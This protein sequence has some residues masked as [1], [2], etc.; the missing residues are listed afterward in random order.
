MRQGGGK[1]Q[2]GKSGWGSALTGLVFLLLATPLVFAALS[3]GVLFSAL[4]LLAGLIWRVWRSTPG[5]GVSVAITE[6]DEGWYLQTDA[7]PARRIMTLRAG[8]V[9]P[10]L[11]SA[12]LGLAKGG[13]NLLV[14][15]DAAP[16]E[17]H[18]ALRR[19]VLSGI[20]S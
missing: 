12:R 10:Y 18:W 3:P 17:T 6:R 5:L 4:T 13:C 15:A 2:I 16:A 19:L 20:R 7:G 8:V 14:F 9:T 11:L 1:I